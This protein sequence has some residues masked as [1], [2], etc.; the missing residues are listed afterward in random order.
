MLDMHPVGFFMSFPKIV[1]LV[2]MIVVVV[3]LKLKFVQGWSVIAPGM[4]PRC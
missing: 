2:L 1:D 3:S 4:V